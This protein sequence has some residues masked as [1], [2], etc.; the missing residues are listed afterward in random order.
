MNA[1]AKSAAALGI[2]AAFAIEPASADMRGLRPS[3][4][5]D[6]IAASITFNFARFA[7]WKSDSA[8]PGP[9]VLCVFD[10]NA[11]DAWAPFDGED[12]GGRNLKVR[13]FADADAPAPD[14]RM[15]FL[16]DAARSFHSTKALADAGVLTISDASNFA[17]RGGAIELAIKDDRFQFEINDEALKDAGVR[18]SSKLLRVGMKVTVSKKDVERQSAERQAVR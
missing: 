11:S 14:C 5:P 9:L 2:V 16:S 3:T 12:V 4:Q 18:I 7:Q 1:I 6:R 15:A 13:L 10:T 17:R 8:T